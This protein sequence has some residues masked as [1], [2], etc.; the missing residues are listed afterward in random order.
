[1][2]EFLCFAD[3][4]AREPAG[5]RRR[6]FINPAAA[7]ISV[8]GGRGYK[9][10]PADVCPG[11]EDRVQNVRQPVHVGG[12]V[13]LLGRGIRGNR[14]DDGGGV[15]RDGRQLSGAQVSGDSLDGG[16]EFLR[17]AAPPHHAV[18]SRRETQP[19]L[20]AKIAATGQ[21]NSYEASLPAFGKRHGLA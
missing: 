18:A 9:Q 14:D 4:A 13:R 1:M 3:D 21:Q 11:D 2:E 19:G 5:F 8:D 7:G 6:A 10:D 16:R 17:R 20:G 15:R 12:T